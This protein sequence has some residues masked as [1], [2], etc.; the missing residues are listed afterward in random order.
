MMINWSWW[1]LNNPCQ[2][3][4]KFSLRLDSQPGVLP[5]FNY[6][7]PK[8]GL[9]I[10][11][12]YW[13]IFVLEYY[14]T[15]ILLHWNITVLEYYCTGILLHWNITVL[16]Y[17][18]TRVL[19][20][21]NVTVLEYYCTRYYCTKILQ[22]KLNWILQHHTG[23]DLRELSQCGSWLPSPYWLLKHKQNRICCELSKPK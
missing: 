16:E 14:C 5:R 6:V 17:Y 10:T 4:G 12:L 9:N 19:L 13:N 3:L 18:C 22:K 20:Y 23:E 15:R 11:A 7:Q 2:V 21:W 1:S 8:V